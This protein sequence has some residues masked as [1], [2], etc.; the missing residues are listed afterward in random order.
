M[1][2]LVTL[3]DTLYCAA[4]LTGITAVPCDVAV[5]TPLW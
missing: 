1:M 4:T 2:L 5:Q 3:S